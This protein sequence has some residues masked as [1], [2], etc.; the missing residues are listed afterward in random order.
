[1]DA[2]FDLRHV[3]DIGRYI[4]LAADLQPALALHSLDAQAFNRLHLAAQ[5]AQLAFGLGGA[6][7]GN[8]PFDVVQLLFKALPLALVNLVA[9][10]P[11]FL[12]LVQV[13]AVIAAVGFPTCY[14][15]FPYL[16]SD[17]IKEV[18]I[19]GDQ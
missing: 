10:L 18:A 11:A 13:S 12:P 17:S 8:V 1:V 7:P 16:L 6:L 5:A 19:V 3:H 4:S 9:Q 2:P 15:H 14:V